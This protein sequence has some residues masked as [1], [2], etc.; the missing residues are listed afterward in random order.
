MIMKYTQ[1]GFQRLEAICREFL[2]EYSIEGKAKHPLV[3][4]DKITWPYHQGGLGIPA[5]H[6]TTQM[7]KIHQ[8]TEILD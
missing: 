2:W 8:V 6:S 1:C 7:L 3:S 4:W 5:F